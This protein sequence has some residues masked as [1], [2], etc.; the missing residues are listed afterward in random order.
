MSIRRRLSSTGFRFVGLYALVYILTTLGF[1]A[2]IF[3]IVGT[4]IEDNIKREIKRDYR[5]LVQIIKS[6]NADEISSHFADLIASTDY[7]DS[8]FILKDDQGS[9]IA[10]NYP[11]K[12]DLGKGWVRL[13]KVTEKPLQQSGLSQDYVFAGEVDDSGNASGASSY[14]GWNDDIGSYSLF[15]GQ[16]RSRIDE[17]KAIVSRIAALVIPISMFLAFLGGLIFNRMTMRRIEVINEHCRSIRA[18]GDLSLRVPNTQPDDEYGLLIANLNAMLDNIDKGVKNIQAVSDDVAHDLRTPLGRLKY[19]LEAGRSDSKATTDSLKII[20]DNALVEIDNLLETFSAILRISQLKSGKRKSK[21]QDFD[22]SAL[23]DTFY[24]AYSPSAEDAGHKMFFQTT[25]ER[26]IINGDKEM[27][28]QLLSNLIENALHHAIGPGYENLEIRLAL[29]HDPSSVILSI[30]DNGRGIPKEYRKQIFNKF[31]KGDYERQDG[32]NG[33]GL[34]LVKAVADLHDAQ[35]QLV[36][37]NSGVKFLVTFT[38]LSSSG[39]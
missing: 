34:A 32:G 35:L 30:E 23:V 38:R 1:M 28:G 18:Q 26:C 6:K 36:A 12:T 24:Q 10:S 16:S 9:V 4:E 33:L 8:L 3:S 15:V 13:S 39:L 11:Y 29:H 2:L 14:I 22:L 19:N 37:L 25:D 27:V 7:L 21:F 5:A 20:L 31:F 17:T